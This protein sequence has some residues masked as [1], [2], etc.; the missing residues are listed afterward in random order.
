MPMP[1]QQPRCY[2]YRTRVLVGP[3]QP[4]LGAA[5]DDAIKAGQARAAPDGTVHWVIQGEIEAG[6]PVGG[7]E[8]PPSAMQ[9]D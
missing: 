8:Q 5:W 9:S 1:A 6:Y 3:W 7:P 4:T 2:R